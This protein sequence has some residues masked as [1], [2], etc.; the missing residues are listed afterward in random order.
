VSIGIP[1]IYD[2]IAMGFKTDRLNPKTTGFQS[3]LSAKTFDRQRLYA[4]IAR[5]DYPYFYQNIR[6]LSGNDESE[7]NFLYVHGEELLAF[8]LVHSMSVSFIDPQ[9]LQKPP[10]GP[11]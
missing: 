11:R 2:L 5:W 10:T 6:C 7:R 1:E 4:I 3:L 9:R 8:G